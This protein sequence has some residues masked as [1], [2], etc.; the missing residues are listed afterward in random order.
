MDK[1]LVWLGSSL[2]DL[3]DMPADVQRTTG[4][5]SA[6]SPTGGQ[7][8]FGKDAIRLPWSKR[9]GVEGKL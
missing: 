7:A 5:D 6:D 8:Q 1:E 3:K 4:F 2:E 9:S